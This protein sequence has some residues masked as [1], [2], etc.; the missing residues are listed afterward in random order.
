MAQDDPAA[1]IKNWEEKFFSLGGLLKPSPGNPAA[2]K[3]DPYLDEQVKEANESF[4][5]AADRKVGKKP[6]RKETKKRTAPLANKRVG[7]KR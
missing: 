2:Q 1:G 3:D 7:R 5:K 6:V 4:R